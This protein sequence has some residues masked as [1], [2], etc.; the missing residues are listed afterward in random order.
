MKKDLS[1]THLILRQCYDWADEIDFEGFLICSVT[2]WERKKD[3][4]RSNMK[5][6]K[7]VCIGTNEE[8]EFETPD[9]Y[10]DT[11]NIQNRI[12]E[13]EFKALK[14]LFGKPDGCD[15]FKLGDFLD[16]EEHIHDSDEDED[17]DD[18]L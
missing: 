3:F 16:L 1:K 13:D 5:H 12:T 10:F 4:I 7:T 18:W 17:D 6:S 15:Y 2:E 8:K 9:Q 11:F 14:R